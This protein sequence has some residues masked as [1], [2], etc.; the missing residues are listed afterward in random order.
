MEAFNLLHDPWIPIRCRSGRTTLHPPWQAFGEANDPAVAVASPRAD[1]D[2]GLVQLLIGLLQTAMPP[3]D[4]DDWSDRAE[5]PPTPR[6]LRERLEPLS[7]AFELLGPGPRFQQDARVASAGGEPWSVEK[8][9]MDLGLDEGPD[10]FARNGSVGSLCLPCAATALATLQ[11][12]APAGGRGHL[13]SVR[14]G[15]PLTTLV[16]P[17]DA[18]AT[19]WTTVWL[20]V[21]PL[22]AFSVAAPDLASHSLFPW[23]AT[24]E[25]GEPAR[26]PELTPEDA[27]RFHAFF[28][29]PRRIWLGQA[30]DGDCGLCGRRRTP[31][32]LDYTT[33]PN[34]IRYTGAW[35]H[36]LSPYRRFKKAQ[37]LAVKGDESGLGY[38]HWLGLVVAPPDGQVRPALPVGELLRS[39]DRFDVARELRLWAFGYAM[40]NIRAEAWSEGF[41]PI[42]AVPAELA[43][44]YAEEI[45]KLVEGAK[46]AENSLCYAFKK[47]VARRPKDV[48]REPAQ[49]S[50]RFWEKTEAFFYQTASALLETLRHGLPVLP[51]SKEWHEVLAREANSLFDLEVAEADFRAAE[52]TQ[53]AR[54]WNELQRSLYGKKLK[55]LL[56]LPIEDPKRKK[57]GR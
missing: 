2:G 37:W 9:L 7:G 19:L 4:E 42:Y 57:G 30:K 41:M 11:T 40:D 36:P 3:A 55:Q 49:I 18:D 6:E 25:P 54:A 5:R 8:L 12:S 43:V 52:P 23:L 35:I 56:G 21:L 1:F 29:M 15:G 22:S 13:T 50:A 31:C 24:P 10:H 38:R 16:V 44:V 39:R 34:G 26:P 48:K 33:R 28:G 20:N 46:L 17:A 45:R 53:V 14:G 51:H 27:H 32:L 47:L